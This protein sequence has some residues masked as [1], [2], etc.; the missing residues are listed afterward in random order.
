M[1]VLAALL[2]ACSPSAAD[3]RPR[4]AH[5][6]MRVDPASGWRAGGTAQNGSALV[7]DAP[8]CLFR[9]REGHTVRAP[10]MIEYYSQSRRPAAALHYVIGT[11]LTGPMGRDLVPVSS[12]RSAAERLRRD[13][14]GERVL[15]FDEV[16]PA[17]VDSL[18]RH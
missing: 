10:W 8:K 11:D 12:D 2:S 16:T 4:C 7:F 18:F 13:H 9:Y 14:H 1:L 15:V 17:I 6:G 3:E 5:C